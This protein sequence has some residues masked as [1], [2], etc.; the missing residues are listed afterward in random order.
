MI[1]RMSEVD[2]QPYNRPN[3]SWIDVPIQTVSQSGE[4]TTVIVRKRSLRAKR[5]IFTI[6][7]TGFTIGLLMI[8]CSSPYSSEFLV[9]GGLTSNHAQIFAGEGSNRCSACHAAGNG[10]IASWL[11]RTVAPDTADG[12]TQSELCMKCHDETL[13]AAAA[14]NPHNVASDKLSAISNHYKQASFNSGTVFQP[15]AI[16][17]NNIACSACHRE[18]HGSQTG[19]TALTDKQ[20]QTCH[21]DSFHSFETGHPEFVSY[22]STR[23]SRIAFDHSSHSMKHFPGKQTDFNCNQCHIDDAFQNVKK[24]ASYEEACSTCHHQQIFESGRDGLALISLPMLD[25]NAIEA[26]DLKIGSW[27]LAATGD[28]DGAIPPIMRVMLAADPQAAEI[29]NRQGSEFDFSD[30]DPN[31]AADVADAV[32][33]TWAIKRLLF[34][35]SLDGPRAVKTRLES[36][37][38][39]KIHDDELRK[40]V[41]NLDEPVFQNAVRRWL[42]NLNVEITNHR[43]GR[44]DVVHSTGNALKDIALK[45]S[46]LAWWPTDEKLLMRAAV[47][48]G[49]L[50]ENPLAGLI[51]TNDEPVIQGPLPI[52]LAPTI[53]LPNQENQQESI[54]KP[55]PTNANIRWKN[56][57]SD[58]LSEPDLL[59]V[60]PLKL[61]GESPNPETPALPIIKSP[62]PIQAGLVNSDDDDS[63]SSEDDKWQ[64]NSRTDDSASKNESV[65]IDRLPVVIP[66]GWFRNDTLFQISYRP[67][68]HADECIQSWIELVTRVADANS[69]PETQQLFEKTISM[70]SIG[71]CR[72]CHTTDRLPDRTFTVNWQATYRDP[73]IRSFTRFAHGPHLIQPNLKDCSHC[74]TLD[75][76]SSNHESFQGFDSAMVASNFFPITKSNCVSCHQANK[77]SNRCT[78]CHSYHV[79]SKLTGTK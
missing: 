65:K 22:P 25:T 70:T 69:R 24:L 59:A 78:Q 5:R 50:A 43:F 54:D 10:S 17:H 49:L 60:N 8:L 7:C 74:H 33:L 27:P 63:L 52:V 39:L 28:F 18:H 55:T 47:D 62:R 72:T 58:P 41:T 6:S 38:G 29:F 32:D 71:L 79:G 53:P 36:V 75:P 11:A 30:I 73:S 2:N 21:Q 76:E 42:P 1:Q 57:H 9:P 4:L 16:E 26:A 51:E 77:T 68:G 35:L 34:E 45:Q 56:I 66:S 37:L 3:D 61:V 31:N 64:S 13:V 67:S 40:M 19:L 44:T 48:R 15:S 23:R 20:C 12:L 46:K 14:L